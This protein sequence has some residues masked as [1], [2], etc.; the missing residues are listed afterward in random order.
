MRALDQGPSAISK[1]ARDRMAE[2]G[3][4]GEM[5]GLIYQEHDISYAG[6]GWCIH[7]ALSTP[8]IQALATLGLP[9]SAL[10]GI[11]NV[12]VV[13]DTAKDLVV[14]IHRLGPSRRRE[15]G[16]V[17]AQGPAALAAHQ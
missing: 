2:R 3:I 9:S 5:L 13:L 17:L 16:R 8:K 4:T 14:T 11:A 15:W 10:G 12:A 1:H 7:L 6:R